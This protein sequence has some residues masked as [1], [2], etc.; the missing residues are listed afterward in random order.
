MSDATSVSRGRLLWLREL[1][2]L[3]RRICAGAG[4]R[5]S[6]NVAAPDRKLMRDIGMSPETDIGVRDVRAAFYAK[7][8][9]R[10]NPLQ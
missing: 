3:C 9:E 6:I 2:K 8:L 7:M 1:A 4:T 10:G 5:K